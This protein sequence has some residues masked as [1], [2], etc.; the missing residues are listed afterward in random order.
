MARLGSI[1]LTWVALF[2]LWLLFQAELSRTLIVAAAGCATVGTAVA[3]Q[4]RAQFGRRYRLEQRWVVRALKVPWLVVSEFL[5]VTR[6]LV[7]ALA[8]WERPSGAF[9]LSPF[10]VG[11]NEPVARARRAFVAVAETYS[12][13]SYVVGMY[14]DEGG[15]L[16]HDLEPQPPEK[17]VL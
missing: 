9:R 8:R 14:A 15:V 13:N 16:I 1:A 17:G 4:V 3:V 2:W 10:P 7:R 5:I 12:P 6:V 11:A